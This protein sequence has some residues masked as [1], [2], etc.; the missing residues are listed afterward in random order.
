MTF[1]RANPDAD[2]VGQVIT[3]GDLTGAVTS[4][5]MSTRG[6]SQLNLCIDV[7]RPAAGATQV[8]MFIDSSDD[9]VNWYP[10]QNK[11]PTVPPLMALADVQETK[12]ISVGTNLWSSLCSVATP[13]TRLRFTATAAMAG[14]VLNVFAYGR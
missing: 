4:L 14:D 12:A 1:V 8:Q 5:I 9:A 3:A 10:V 7:T 6:M 2:G 11:D 13:F